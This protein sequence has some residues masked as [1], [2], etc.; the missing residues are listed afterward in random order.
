MSADFG[1]PSMGLHGRPLED[2]SSS[3]PSSLWLSSADGGVLS[4]GSGGGGSNEQIRPPQ[5]TSRGD[6]GNT[7]ASVD[8]IGIS[9][10]SGQNA[11]HEAAL[12]PTNGTDEGPHAAIPHAET[13][14]L[15]KPRPRS[16]RKPMSH[17]GVVVRPG[18]T[19][20]EVM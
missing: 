9:T 12:I 7:E 8:R 5:D 20:E 3:A 16:R 18:S 4:S 15:P 11:A 2:L 1:S 17:L 14:R 6:E 19:L 13:M 10:V